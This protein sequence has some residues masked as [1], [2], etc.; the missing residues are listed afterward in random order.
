MSGSMRDLH[1]RI[2]SVSSTQ[3]M[4]R[5]MRT[6]AVAKYSRAQTA[7]RAFEPYRAACERLLRASGGWED[8]PR[9]VKRVCY[10]AVAANRGLCGSYNLELVRYL[11][12]VLAE[13]K[14]EYSVVL[15][16]PVAA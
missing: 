3:Q 13:E 12:E 9:P 10:V 15:C 16:R 8:A 2:R 4:T 1:R 7:A 11:A 6:V 5:A 14:Q